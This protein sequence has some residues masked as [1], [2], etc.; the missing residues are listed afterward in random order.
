[1]SVIVSGVGGADRSRLGDRQGGG[2]IAVQYGQG[3]A[4]I[5]WVVPQLVHAVQH[6]VRPLNQRNPALLTQ[7]GQLCRP[8]TD[9]SPSAGQGLAGIIDPVADGALL[10]GDALVNDQPF[11]HPAVAELVPTL[12]DIL[13]EGHIPRA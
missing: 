5:M 8:F 11:H 13:L 7:V 10:T 2:E 1:M 4:A 3:W 9:V 12:A 6:I